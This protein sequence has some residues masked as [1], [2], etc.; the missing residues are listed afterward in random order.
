MSRFWEAFVCI[1]L[2]G[3]FSSV[4]AH[5]TSF[6]GATSV[7]LMNSSD[8][9]QFTAHYSLHHRFSLGAEVI[10]HDLENATSYAGLARFGL[11]LH[12]WN[13]PLFQANAYLEGGIGSARI[14][15]D[16]SL[17]YRTRIQAD[18]E[19]RR[20][21]FMT[22]VER[23]EIKDYYSDW[24]FKSR[25]GL[26]PYL[27]EFNEINAWLILQHEFQ[28]DSKEHEVSPLLRVFYKNFL[29]E[30][31]SSLKGKWMLNMMFHF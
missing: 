4:E 26:A 19:D 5:P 21:L 22:S 10:R 6:K 12:R 16:Q 11:L 31:G 28:T 27:A 8:H 29:V 18:I 25:V 1:I 3:T 13:H 17:A 20:Y 7:E 15:G 2:L 24:N 23:F 9:S 14:D 30:A